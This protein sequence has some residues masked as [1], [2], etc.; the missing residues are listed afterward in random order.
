M[1]N[2][3]K[4]LPRRAVSSKQSPRSRSTQVLIALLALALG[5]CSIQV[6]DSV[7]SKG[8]TAYWV[9]TE[10]QPKQTNFLTTDK[11]V[12]L[13]IKFSYNVIASTQVFRVTWFEP[14][15]KP[16]IAGGVRTIYGSN[17]SLIVS[18]K[19]DGTTASQKP[20]QWRV[21][22][23]YGAEQLVDREFTIEAP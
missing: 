10:D 21:K 15:G 1:F 7:L 12:T 8:A 3:H 6:S 18:L 9:W 23:H 11:Q 22:V 20:G 2:L 16:Y 13:H 17:D 14:S 4:P 5:G 19:I